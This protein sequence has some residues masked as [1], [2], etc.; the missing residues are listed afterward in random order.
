MIPHADAKTGYEQAIIIILGIAV[1][2][3]LS[4]SAVME[5]ASV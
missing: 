2:R 5:V 1:S 3:K 4:V